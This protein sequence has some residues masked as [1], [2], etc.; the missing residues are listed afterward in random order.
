M[1]KA[2]LTKLI[3]KIFNMN[4][5]ELEDYARTVS[6]SNA[7]DK[8]KYFLNKAIDLRKEELALWDTDNAMLINGDYD[9]EALGD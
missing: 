1:D 9:T 3:I 8:A 7:D 2:T 4:N 5:R 6:M